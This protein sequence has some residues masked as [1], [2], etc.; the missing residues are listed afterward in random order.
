MGQE[1]KPFAYRVTK[2]EGHSK[3]FQTLPEM[4]SVL[5]VEHILPDRITVHACYAGGKEE[6][7]PQD[8]YAM[9]RDITEEEAGLFV[10]GYKATYE[11]LKSSG[12]K[13]FFYEAMILNFNPDDP[14]E[15]QIKDMIKNRPVE[16]L[17]LEDIVA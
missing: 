14:E 4:I 2:G 7:V 15:K 10:R 9:Q 17:E 1:Q 11:N 16:W 13:R 6:L 3:V 12:L 5:K 8:K